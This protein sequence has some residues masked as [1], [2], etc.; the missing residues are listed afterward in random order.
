MRLHDGGLAPA[1]NVQVAVDGVH[2]L[3]AGV[4]VVNDPQ[5]GQQI[6][7]A[8]ER[9]KQRWGN[10][11]PQALADEAYTNLESVLEMH[12][13]AIDYYSTWTGRNKAAVGRGKQQHKDYERDQFGFDG[14]QRDDLSAGA[15]LG[16][17]P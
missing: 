2:G 14:E 1:Y 13:R 4:E 12:E 15:T 3:I 7:P 6:V 9:L 10:Y 5:D 11:P 8:M 17:S 16:L